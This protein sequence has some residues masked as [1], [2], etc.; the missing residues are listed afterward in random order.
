MQGYWDVV[1]L[2]EP[3]ALVLWMAMVNETG[4]LLQRT[5][6]LHP[7]PAGKMAQHRWDKELQFSHPTQSNFC[8]DN[9]QRLNY[10]KPTYKLSTRIIYSLWKATGG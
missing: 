1:R 7:G 2:G 3:S 10:T 5:A 9:T 6:N 8:F 4:S